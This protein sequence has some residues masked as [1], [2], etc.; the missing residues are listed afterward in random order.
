MRRSW[1]ITWSRVRWSLP[2]GR[3]PPQFDAGGAVL[4]VVDDG[5]IEGG[6]E[7]RGHGSIPS[8]II[9]PRED[10]STDFSGVTRVTP[11][12]EKMAQHHIP[13]SRTSRAA[14]PAGAVAGPRA[15]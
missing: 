10:E 8:G 6:V 9:S 14:G 2:P 7:R 1:Y 13:A 15:G 5:V 3:R 12:F 4:A 11:P